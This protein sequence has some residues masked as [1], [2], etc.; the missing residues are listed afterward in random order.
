[1]KRIISLVLL[2]SFFASSI[3]N[4]SEKPTG[5]PNNFEFKKLLVEG[6][7]PK[8]LYSNK[9]RSYYVSEEKLPNGETNYY[10]P[11]DCDTPYYRDSILRTKPMNGNCKIISFGEYNTSTPSKFFIPYKKNQF[12]E[13]DIEFENGNI[14]VSNIGYRLDNIRVIL[15]DPKTKMTFGN[16]MDIK[17]LRYIFSQFLV[18]LNQKEDILI[19]LNS[20][21]FQAIIINYDNDSL[22]LIYEINGLQRYYRWNLLNPKIMK[23]FI[24]A[25]DD[26]SKRN[27]YLSIL[28]L[29]NKDNINI[30]NNDDINSEDDEKLRNNVGNYLNI[31][32]STKSSNKLDFI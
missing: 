1:M 19:D 12:I 16:L 6:I 3:A 32:D 5:N 21:R 8:T 11:N 14:N 27:E 15:K 18:K 20:F 31:S 10:I 22:Y 13:S 2:S 28:E 24:N 30:K 23:L 4:C 25:I 9:F 29:E 7:I 17:K 26:E